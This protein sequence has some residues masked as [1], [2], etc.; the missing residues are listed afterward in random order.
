MSLSNPGFSARPESPNVPKS[1][2]DP[3]VHFEFGECRVCV[4]LLFDFSFRHEPSTQ[5]CSERYFGRTQDIAELSARILYS[6]GG[7]FLVTGFRGVG[8][9]SFVNQVIRA[10]KSNLKQTDAGQVRLV[11]IYMSLPRRME[12]LQLMHYLVRRLY[13]RL[14]ELGIF[15]KLDRTVQARLLLAY[16]RTS[17]MV[18]HHKTEAQE[19]TFG[20][21]LHWDVSMGKRWH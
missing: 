7:T 17:V 15:S 18:S 21:E 12:P 8:K 9:T 4:P 10:L 19:T 16:R 14:D 1:E 20:S 11:D 5:D 6:D 3:G 2:L 13:E